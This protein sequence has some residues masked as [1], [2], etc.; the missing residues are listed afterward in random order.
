MTQFVKPTSTTDTEMPVAQECSKPLGT[1]LSW[2]LIEHKLRT[3]LAVLIALCFPTAAAVST[4]LWVSKGSVSVPEMVTNEASLIVFFVGTYTTL[5]TGNVAL[6]RWTV[7]GSL[8]LAL[9]PP[10]VKGPILLIALALFIGLVIGR[11]AHTLISPD[12][13]SEA[14]DR[15]DAHQPGHPADQYRTSAQTSLTT[16]AE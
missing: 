13:A 15:A 7:A 10:S 9:P 2:M 4:T 3:V 11:L 6:I 5:V 16:E 14:A 8:A 12:K 1:N